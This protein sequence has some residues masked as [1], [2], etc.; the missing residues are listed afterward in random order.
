[1]SIKPSPPMSRGTSLDRAAIKKVV[2]VGGCFDIVHLGHIKFLE[3][4]KKIGDNLI[5]LLES[6]ENIKKSKGNN[7]PINNQNDRAEFLMNLKMVDEV[8]KLPYMKSD[9]D[10][11]EILRKIKPDIIAVSEG[12]KNLEK[13]KL[14]AKII[15][16]KVVEVTKKIANQSTS[17]IIEIIEI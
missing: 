17:R 14:Q 7:R 13:K 5:V 16:F 8:I 12:D 11:L 2:V 3:K 1:M 10:Y 15:G 6:D 4:A 9:D